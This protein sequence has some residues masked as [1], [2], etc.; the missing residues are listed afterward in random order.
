LRILTAVLSIC[1]TY[2]VAVGRRIIT[3]PGSAQVI[4]YAFEM[5]KR[6][7]YTKLACA[8]KANIMKLTDGMFLEVFQD[9][10]KEYPEIEA[11]QTL[12]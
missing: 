1:L 9:I 11:S 8:H 7:G 5:A 4:R 2:D 10:A 6:K 12:L 3:R